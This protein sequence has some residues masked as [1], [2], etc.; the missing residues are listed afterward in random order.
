MYNLKQQVSIYP[1][2]NNTRIRIEANALYRVF[3]LV[4][5]LRF[6]DHVTYYSGNFNMRNLYVVLKRAQDFKNEY[7]LSVHPYILAEF[8]RWNDKRLKLLEIKK[9]EISDLWGHKL[10]NKDGL[11]TLWDFQTVD[12]EFMVEA[13][14]VYNANEMGTGKTVEAAVT[15]DIWRERFKGDMKHGLIICPSTLCSS[16]RDHL[17]DWT[18]Y[19]KD[20]IL[21]ANQSAVGDRITPLVIGQQDFFDGVV[22]TP[23]ETLRNPAIIKLIE[24]HE[25]SYIVADE[26]H[27]ARNLAAKQSSHF[28]RTK[29]VS[30]R[31]IGLSGTGVVNYGGDLYAIVHWLRPDQYDNFDVFNEDFVENPRRTIIKVKEGKYTKQEVDALEQELDYLMC[32]RE[33][34]DVLKDLPEKIH[35]IVNL[36][37]YPAQRKLYEQMRDEWIV[38]LSNDDDDFVATKIVIAQ[39]MKLKELAISPALLRLNQEPFAS[40]KII[41]Y[42]DI[43]GLDSS[44]KLDWLFNF[45]DE[46]LGRDDKMVVFSQ[47]EG[48]LKLIEARLR[49]SNRWIEEK[50]GYVRFSGGAQ[51]HSQ[52]K[53]GIRLS[54]KDA[55]D[56]QTLFNDDPHTGLWLST[57]KKGG[58]GL[59]LTGANYVTNT[60][61]WWN[62][63]TMDQAEDRTH[64]IGQKRAVTVTNLVA[65]NTVEQKILAMLQDKTGLFNMM[66]R[67]R[68]MLLELLIEDK[69]N[70]N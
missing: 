41:N 51:F 16:W 67:S 12:I 13:L 22:V 52:P 39:L 25:Y 49:I 58:E 27:R 15:V 14:Q 19:T 60:D 29:A 30:K 34:K 3:P 32:R 35:N 46:E 69:K 8:K 2:N 61:Y 7:E 62:Q 57:L 4:R 28:I 24:N 48:T 63:T 53:T 5:K 18:E 65:E 43:A 50:Y 68:K 40:K 11:K 70:V 33:K 20:Q 59:T 44:C 17:L 54:Y 64:R 55:E 47:W 56:L 66:I 36:E 26:I 6:T 23:W 21:I 10:T 9:K 37:L 38:S 45:L 42:D 31:K 1:T